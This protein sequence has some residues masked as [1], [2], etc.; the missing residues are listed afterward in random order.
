MK[1]SWGSGLLLTYLAFM[2]IILAAVFFS[3]TQDV[4]LVADNYYE[5]ELTHQ[6]EIDK[7]KRAEVLPE[8]VLFVQTDSS[9]V[10][11][12]P[13]IFGSNKIK[14]KVR[15]YRPDDN[16]EDFVKTIVLNDSFQQEVLLTSLKKG[17]WKVSVDWFV[18][19]ISYLSTKNLMVN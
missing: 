18:N 19:D 17:L 10:I 9:L 8:K 6:Q 15:F 5:R 1:I 3:F 16:Q 14:G 11:S 7:T 13:N 2:A 12:F 4:N